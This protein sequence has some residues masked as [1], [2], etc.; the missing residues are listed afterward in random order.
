[1]F[2][3]SSSIARCCF[4]DQTW[5]QNRLLE[6][7]WML[8]LFKRHPSCTINSSRLWGV[9]P[10]SRL[11]LSRSPSDRELCRINACPIVWKRNFRVQPYAL[12]LEYWL[13]YCIS[14][15]ILTSSSRNVISKMFLHFLHYSLSFKV[16]YLTYVHA[17][18]IFS[19]QACVGV[20]LEKQFSIQADSNYG[21]EIPYSHCRWARLGSER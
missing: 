20:K 15:W 1:M 12:L 21:S 7:L 9:F 14:S 10:V 13:A 16:S 11:A 3:I 18:I 4:L 2:P 17:E 19:R 6:S 5:W 8:N